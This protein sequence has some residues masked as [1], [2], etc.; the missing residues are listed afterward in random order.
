MPAQTKSVLFTQCLQNDFVAPLGPWDAM[1]CVLHIGSSEASRLVGAD[2]DDGPVARFLAWAHAAPRESLEI[3]HV[4]DLHSKVDPEQADHL[5][6]FG[7]HCLEGS[8]GAEFVF[9]LPADASRYQTVSSTTLN[10]FL[11]TD[12]E[13][14]LARILPGATRVG[15]VGAWTDA[16]VSFLAYEL[17][18]RHPQLE[19]AVCSALAA[20]SSRERHLLALDHLER[21]IGVRVFHSIGEFCHFLSPDGRHAEDLERRKSYLGAVDLQIEG[22]LSDPDRELLAWLCRDASKVQA[23]T[24]AGGFSGNA[25]LAVESFDVE[26][27]RQCPHVVKIGPRQA[28]GQERISFETIEPI[29]G[30]SAPRIADFSDLGERGGIKYRY[31][32]MTAGKSKTFQGLWQKGLDAPRTEAILRTVFE[33]QLGRLYQAASPEPVDL[34]ALWGFDSKWADG[35]EKTVRGLGHP[36]P[37]GVWEILPG[38]DCLP[39]VPFYRDTLSRAKG[40][41]REMVPMARVHG[42]L[43]GANILIDGNANVWLIDF[44][45]SRRHHVVCDFAKL[46]NDLLHIWTPLQKESDLVELHRLLLALMKVEDLGVPLPTA[47]EAGIPESMVR[48]WETLAV[49]RSSMAKPLGVFRDPWQQRIAALRYAVHTLSFDEPDTL[50]KQGGLLHAGLLAEHCREHLEQDRRLR[51]DWVPL[52]GA[53]GR[54]GLTLLPGRRD[55]GRDLS[56]DAD[57]LR[58]LGA[59]LVVS[60]VTQE[61]LVEFGVE[62]LSQELARR[63]IEWI[64]SPILDQRACGLE[65]AEDL[66]RRITEACFQGRDV[67]IHCLGGIGRSGMIAACVEVLAGMDAHEAIAIVRQH[68]SPRALETRAQCELVESYATMER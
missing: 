13:S 9:P 66:S 47:Q 23:R 40:R 30:N 3:V 29:L 58:E 67:V 27:R 25:V 61:E 55:R 59:K 7:P 34:L 52:Q 54:M 65:Q 21:V 56:E 48:T 20:S 28:I 63:G 2:P 14:V 33:E 22:P 32:S 38:L 37:E 8:A 43:N 5:A 31:A 12:M 16:K 15:I 39:V 1:P 4:R 18:T 36:Q 24:L 51:V 46:E 57:R 10:D 62:E 11:R 6:H 17:R 26:G 64:H 19:I 50:Q 49:L 68:R 53:T 60:L 41:L 44:F 45:H 35:V 42:D